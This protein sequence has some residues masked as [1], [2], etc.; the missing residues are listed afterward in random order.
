MSKRIEAIIKPDLLI[1]A[2]ESAGFT[3]E[4]AA[5]KLRIKLQKLED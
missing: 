4:G 3:K 2:R 1:W 5:D